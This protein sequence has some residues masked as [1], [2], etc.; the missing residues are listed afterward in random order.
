M[1]RSPTVSRSN[2]A[3]LDKISRLESLD[4]TVDCSAKGAPNAA[5][6]VSQHQKWKEGPMEMVWMTSPC[7]FPQEHSGLR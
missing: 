2:K 6:F 7:V 5:D 4:C 1:F 3:D